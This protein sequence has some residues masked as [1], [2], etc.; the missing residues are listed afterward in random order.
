MSKQD[1]F[2]FTLAMLIF[3]FYFLYSLKLKIANSPQGASQY[4]TLCNIFNPGFI[5]GKA[6]P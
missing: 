4:D 1:F 5:K 3:A 2:F 6:L